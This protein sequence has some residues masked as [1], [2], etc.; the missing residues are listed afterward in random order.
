MREHVLQEASAGLSQS[1]Y[2]GDVATDV[3]L[4]YCGESE[5]LFVEQSR[6]SVLD[7]V[8]DCPSA[9]RAGCRHI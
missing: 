1:A 8:L 6:Q 2:G 9:T 3:A 7:V 4:V 5:L